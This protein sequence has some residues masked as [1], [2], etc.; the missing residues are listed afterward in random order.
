MPRRGPRG[1]EYPPMPGKKR[2][3]EWGGHDGEVLGGRDPSKEMRTQSQSH[4]NLPGLLTKEHA[5]LAQDVVSGQ[6]FRLVPC[7]R[8]PDCGR[9][10]RQTGQSFSPGLT[11]RLV[12]IQSRTSQSGRNGRSRRTRLHVIP[13]NLASISGSNRRPLTDWRHSADP[14]GEA[15]RGLST[16]VGSCTRSRER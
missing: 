3:R 5:L 6:G 9:G 1:R 4:D 12:C 14:S 10:C 8:R 16:I 2:K 15:R 13:L 11:N 7:Q